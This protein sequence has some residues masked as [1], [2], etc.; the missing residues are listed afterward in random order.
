VRGTFQSLILAAQLLLLILNKEA[1]MATIDNDVSPS[2]C[3][4]PRGREV[5]RPPAKEASWL[6]L[7][8]GT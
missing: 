8:H 5:K 3:L 1:I 4:H 2:L 7:K 6:P